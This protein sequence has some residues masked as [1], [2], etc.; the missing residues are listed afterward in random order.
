MIKT[1]GSC[2]KWILPWFTP[3]TVENKDLSPEF[4]SKNELRPDSVTGKTDPD[5]KPKPIS[6]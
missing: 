4:L 2:A 1:I 5:V 6:Y 3:V